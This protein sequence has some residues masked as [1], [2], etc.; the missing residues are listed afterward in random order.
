[1]IGTISSLAIIGPS[2]PHDREQRP[3][4]VDDGNGRAADMRDTRQETFDAGN[5]RL[6]QVR[7][8]QRQDEHDERGSCHERHDDDRGEHHD[9][10]QDVAGAI[11]Q[12]NHAPRPLSAQ[13]HLGRVLAVAIAGTL[14]DA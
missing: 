2:T 13:E 6:E 3:D 9:R 7:Q 12:R 4:R 5:D 1:M 11:I 14:S 8:Q 10:R